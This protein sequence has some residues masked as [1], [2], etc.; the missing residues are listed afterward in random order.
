MFLSLKGS[1]KNQPRDKDGKWAK[2]GGAIKTA[3]INRAKGQAHEY[4]R[5]AAATRHYTGYKKY[6]AKVT[7]PSRLFQKSDRSRR[8]EAI[9]DK[10]GKASS[11]I[12]N[13][14]YAASSARRAS[15]ISR[16]LERLRGRFLGAIKEWQANQARWPKGHPLGGQWKDDGTASANDA[17]SAINKVHRTDFPQPR[18]DTS[19]KF[20]R[21]ME[22][23]YNFKTGVVFVRK[24][25]SP[26]DSTHEYGHYIA[27]KVMS[28]YRMKGAKL[29]KVKQAI[30]DSPQIKMFEKARLHGM[31]EFAPG[32]LARVSPKY[33]N[34]FISGEEKWAR[35]YA[36]YVAIKSKNPKL[37]KGLRQRQSGMLPMQ[38]SDKEFEPI[39]NAIDE[40]LR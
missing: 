20:P 7:R 26:F 36:Q 10:V 9:A 8:L 40:A 21:K 37:L 22:A 5:E 18:V 3:L 13:T 16:N 11:P 29:A 25:T 19:G 33:I 15:K 39:Y 2:L 31:V 12:L 14:S 4:L 35:A 24:N 32:K 38:W 23:A 6:V 34:Y 17:I 27:D 28:D 1:N 30:D